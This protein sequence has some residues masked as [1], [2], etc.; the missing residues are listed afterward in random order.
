[1]S[2]DCVWRETGEEKRHALLGSDSARSSGRLNLRWFGDMVAGRRGSA[3]H[4]L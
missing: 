3:L 2:H 1:M 4:E